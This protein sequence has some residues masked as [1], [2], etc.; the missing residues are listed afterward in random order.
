MEAQMKQVLFAGALGALAMFVWA[1]VAHMATPLGTTGI[2]QLAS[3]Q[4]VLTAVQQQAG[5]QS[6]LFMYPSLGEGPNA[7][8]EY[9]QK[10]ATLPSGLL[11]YHPPGQ[12]RVFS[13]RLL[14]V[15]FLTE[16]IEVTLVVWLLAQARLP[17]YGSR[18]L[19]VSVAGLVAAMATNVPYWNWY[20]FPSSY[21]AANIFTEVVGFIAAGLVAARMVSPAAAGARAAVALH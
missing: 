14:I 12:G 10:L 21:T 8:E 9:S 7:M 2:R 16:V 6:G 11:L 17:R 19:F 13:A 4:P 3:E 20:G 18:V 15:E 5:A 1:S